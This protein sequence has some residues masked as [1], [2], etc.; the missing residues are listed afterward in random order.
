MTVDYSSYLELERLLELQHPRTEPPEHDELLFIVIHQVYELWFKVVL[1]EGEQLRDAL[2]A[3]DVT[4]AR[5]ALDR[6]LTIFRV[7]VDQVG[8][9]ETMTPMAFA[10]FRPGL[11][12]ASGFQS[13]QFRELELLLGQ[14]DLA[15]LKHHAE[16][17]PARQQL[18][19]RLAEPGLY[20]VFLRFLVRAGHPIS[21]AT[22]D[23]VEAAPGEPQAEV[24]EALA[25]LYQEDPASTQLCEKM[26][27]FDEI[28]QLWRYRHVQ[29]VERFL[30]TKSG[31]GGS[32]GATYLRGTLFRPI[33]RDLWDMRAV[34]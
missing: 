1:Q 30:G 5:R 34:I 27:D 11:G 16:G 10:A 33:F 9:L 4:T 3:D 21:A 32:T 17:S 24:Q 28:I 13:Y 26:V 31:T 29:L 25:T 18:E 14:R 15:C 7:L 2:E 8:V 12:G 19:R 6:L 23:R 20:V 22:L